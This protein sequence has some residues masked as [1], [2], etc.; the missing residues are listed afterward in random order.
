MAVD[1][2][3]SIAYMYS[4]KKKG[5]YYDMDGG[6]TGLDGISG[7]C[8]GTLYEG[9]RKAGMPD[10]GW[11]LNTDSMH[12]WLLKNGWQL[13]AHNKDWTAKR[14]DVV[15]FGRK[16]YSGGAAGHVVQFI[17]NTKIIHCTYKSAT[18]NGVYVDK[19]ATTCPYSMGWYVYRLKSSAKAKPAKK[20]AKKSTKAKITNTKKYAN[21]DTV[22]LLNHATK[23]QTGEKI[24]ASKRNHNYT[25]KGVKKV[26]Q[27]KSRYAFL[28][29]GINSWVLAQDLQLV[30]AKK[31]PAKTK[32][33]SKDYYTSNPGKVK[34]LHDDG[35]YL[36]TDVDFKKGH[37]GGNFKKG[38][39]FVISGIKK[40]KDGLPRLV[41]QSGYLLTANRKY[42]K[43]I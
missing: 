21:G 43:K 17:S 32:N 7:D 9:L 15:I 10:A 12:N 19:E 6:R 23:Y 18:R 2:E 20:P 11:I 36:K 31:A 42:V 13:I 8:S 34:L 39:V 3:K 33:Y 28:L 27:S 35:L 40:R 5:I 29:S 38:T 22:K 25:V 37:K 30:K 4:L 41:T 1:I 24:L 14:G 26:N 16:G